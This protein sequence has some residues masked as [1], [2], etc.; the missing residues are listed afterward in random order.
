MPSFIPD[1]T[2]ILTFAIAAFVLAITPGPD[3]ALQLS[4]SLNYGRSHGIATAI[5]IVMGMA[6]GVYLVA[7]RMGS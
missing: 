7:R 4:R 6:G 1:L 2:T 5:G 3:M